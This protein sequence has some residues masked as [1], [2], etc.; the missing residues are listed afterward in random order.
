MYHA[1]RGSTCPAL[2]GRG[3][4]W[5]DHDAWVALFERYD[6]LILHC[7]H[8]HNLVGADADEVRQETWIEVAKRL[9]RFRYDPGGSFR[10]W[11]WV[12]CRNKAIS[13]MRRNNLHRAQG[14]DDWT[15][16]VLDGSDSFHQEDARSLKLFSEAARIQAAVRSVVEPRSW[17]A[18]WLADVYE[19][20]MERVA[21]LLGLSRAAAY[22]AVQ[23]VRA[24]LRDE[25]VKRSASL[26]S[27][28]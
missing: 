13:F 28:R 22:K 8:R 18:F 1:D 9:R 10:A 19:W 23:R 15:A 26:T 16:G 21:T 24:R 2:L 20:E 3:G 5:N 12:V 7:C 17:E 25:G 6:D 4:D 11:L 14:L 27:T